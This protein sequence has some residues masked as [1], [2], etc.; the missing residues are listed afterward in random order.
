MSQR[1]RARSKNANRSAVLCVVLILAVLCMV[2]IAIAL[3]SPDTYDG[4]RVIPEAEDYTPDDPAARQGQLP[5][6]DLV[7]ETEH[8]DQ[9]FHYLLNASVSF[10]KKGRSGNVYLENCAGNSGYM[11]VVYTLYETGEELY[12]SPLL[13][14]DWSI[15][16]D[17]LDQIPAPGQYPVAAVIYVY[18][19]ADADEYIGS[20]EESINITVG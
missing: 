19:S 15:Q 12:R 11:Q 18:E 10:D 4:G 3:L 17:D 13:P 5:K 8:S 20:F 1:P 2:G 9:E 14:P 16:T 6:L 7:R